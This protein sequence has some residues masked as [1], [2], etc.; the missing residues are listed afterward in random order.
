MSAGRLLA[1]IQLQFSCQRFPTHFFPCSF[2]VLLSALSAPRNRRRR[3]RLVRARR[4]GSGQKAGETPVASMRMK[5]PSLRAKAEVPPLLTLWRCFA[6]DGESM[7]LRPSCPH[8][9]GTTAGSGQPAGESQMASTRTETLSL[10]A[11]AMPRLSPRVDAGSRRAGNPPYQHGHRRVAA[12]R[13]H[14]AGAGPSARALPTGGRGWG[15]GHATPGC[16]R[17]QAQRRRFA[18][19]SR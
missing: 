3:A 12:R 15:R 1:E 2:R 19:A 5:T 8:K 18:M 7:N 16:R 17:R 6:T 14:E 10:R 9:A 13:P 11:E 4:Q